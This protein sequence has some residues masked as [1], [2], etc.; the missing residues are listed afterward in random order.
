VPVHE[1]FKSMPNGIP[2]ASFVEPVLQVHTHPLEKS[3]SEDLQFFPPNDVRLR[4][5][6]LELSR[7]QS[8]HD[9]GINLIRFLVSK[10]MCSFAIGHLVNCLVSLTASGGQ[11]DYFIKSIPLKAI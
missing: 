4:A 9:R 8:L 11:V 5:Q 10:W 2:K 7:R 1:F 3:L 6:P